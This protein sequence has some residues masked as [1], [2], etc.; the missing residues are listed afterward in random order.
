MT[1][2]RKKYLSF[3]PTIHAGHVVTAITILFCAVGTYFGVQ[4]DIAQ[5]KLVDKAH[6]S[7]LADI[8]KHATD[9]RE[10]TDRKFDSLVQENNHALSKLRDD[11]NNWFMTLNDKLDR[12]ADKR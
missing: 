3:D 9:E 11:M 12:K 8:E 6:D 4:N 2:E 1:E 5:L 10:R 7:R